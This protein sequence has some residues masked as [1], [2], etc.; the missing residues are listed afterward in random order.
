MQT[1]GLEACGFGGKCACF[2][3]SPCAFKKN[4]FALEA[5]QKM[6]AM[7]NELLLNF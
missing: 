2:L 5:R 1:A 3:L 7:P 4:S 6:P